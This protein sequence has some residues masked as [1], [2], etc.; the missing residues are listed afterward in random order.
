MKIATAIAGS[1]AFLLISSGWQDVATVVVAFI[2]LW[3]V[4][5]IIFA[6]D[7]KSDLHSDL[8]QK[9]ISLAAEIE[10][11]PRTKESLR[12]LAADRL[13]IE[14]REPPCKRLVDLQARND[15]CRA[16]GFLSSDLVPLSDSQRY[17][18]YFATFGMSRLEKWKASNGE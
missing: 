11:A 9:F 14:A 12:A 3:A 2:A 17:L 13:S 15:E 6:P 7:K 10:A 18:G 1:G 8:R 16:R 5:D 4:I